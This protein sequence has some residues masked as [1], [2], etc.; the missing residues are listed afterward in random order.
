MDTPP[1]T[2][3]QRFVV[4]ASVVDMST[5]PQSGVTLT[6]GIVWC[7]LLQAKDYVVVPA[8]ATSAA[9]SRLSPQ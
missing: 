5:A 9:L 4:C 8:P 7:S 1:T 3:S 2:G 6:P